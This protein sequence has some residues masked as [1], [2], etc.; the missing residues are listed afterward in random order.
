MG[1]KCALTLSKRCKYL[2][3]GDE[4]EGNGVQDVSVITHDICRLVRLLL[5]IYFSSKVAQII[6]HHC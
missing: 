2:A 4:E 6:I 5:A 1:V 3:V